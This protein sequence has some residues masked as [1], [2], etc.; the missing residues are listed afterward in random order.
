MGK[1]RDALT[2]KMGKDSKEIKGFEDQY[3]AS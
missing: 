3:R 2:E 1:K